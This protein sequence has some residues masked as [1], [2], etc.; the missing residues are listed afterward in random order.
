MTK[1]ERWLLSEWLIARDLV[2]RGETLL[3]HRERTPYAEV[4][5]V[6]ENSEFV[7]VVE[8][9]SWNRGLWGDLWGASVITQKQVSRLLAACHVLGCRFQRPVR[10]KIAVVDYPS[11]ELRY[12]DP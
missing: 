8:V 1:S 3:A 4:D 5:L 9:K 11:L 12:F 6:T 10:L 2:S 7:T